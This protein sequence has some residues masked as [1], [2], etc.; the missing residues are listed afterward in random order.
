MRL[1]ELLWI[2]AKNLKGRLAILPA[3]AIAISAFCLCF[4][5]AA[6]VTV[7]QEKALPYELKVVSDTAKLSDGAVAKLAGIPDVTAVTPVLEV[8]VSMAAGEYKA[9]LTLTGISATYINEAFTQGGA[10]PD[11]SVMPYIVLNEA[12]CKLFGEPDAHSDTADDTQA[13]P[14]DWLSTAVFIMTSEGTKPVVSKIV[15]IMAKDDED[16]TPAAYIS[17]AAAK[18]LLKQE[19]QSTDGIGAA[20]RVKNAGY[21]AGASEQI[22]A[23]GFGVMNA[24]QEVQAKWDSELSNMTYLILIGVYGLLSSAFFEAACLKTYLLEHISTVSAL[25]WIGMKK[26]DIGKLF[27]IQSVITVLI[28]FAEGIIVSIS[29][30]AFLSPEIQETSVFALQIPFGAAAVSAAVCFVAGLFPLLRFNRLTVS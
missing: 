15:G 13:P 28:G 23:L 16:E 9:Q 4:A 11:N 29:L 17:I 26:G 18:A 21:A 12:A 6:L 24:N 5:G 30:P 3:A 8:P 14:L 1:S 19:G 22:A 27:V 7:Q 25:L 10:F 20:V 2:A